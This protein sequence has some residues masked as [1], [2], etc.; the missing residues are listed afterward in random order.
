MTYWNGSAWEA[1][2]P[3]TPPRPRRGRRLLGAATEA[4]LITLL[5]FGLIAGTAIGARGSGPSK[6]SAVLTVAPSPVLS[7]GAEYS[8]SGSG[9][10]PNTAVNVVISMPT[11]CAFF[12]VTA[13]AEGDVWFVYRTG[14]PGHYQIEASQRLNARKLT[15]MA[16][17]YFDVV[18]P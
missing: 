17:T 1:E 18:A 4:G 11:C 3:A 10:K 15:L 5:I 2:R 7:D 6:T 8:V 14:A 9:F 16:R 12:T 13:D